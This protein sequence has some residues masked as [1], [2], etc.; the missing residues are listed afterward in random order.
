MRR[1][2][3]AAPNGESPSRTGPR[4][5]TV[6]QLPACLDQNRAARHAQVL[7][8]VGNSYPTKDGQAA[9]R[10]NVSAEDNATI[11]RNSVF[12]V[13]WKEVY[14]FIENFPVGTEKGI[15]VESFACF[16]IRRLFRLVAAPAGRIAAGCSMAWHAPR[17]ASGH[18]AWGE[19]RTPRAI[20]VVLLA[21]SSVPTSP[22][23]HEGGCS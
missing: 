21:A 19:A 22:S 18:Q 17:H 1:T 16:M 2:S 8:P 10:R 23:A 5:F 12:D 11:R 3:G 13:E 6:W 9:T 4:C 14:R 20:P 7:L 15:L